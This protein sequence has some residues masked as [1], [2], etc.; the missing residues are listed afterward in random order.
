MNFCHDAVLCVYTNFG[1]LLKR[2][3]SHK[4]HW[5]GFGTLDSG[6]STVTLIEPRCLLYFLFFYQQMFTLFT[7]MG[8]S[9]LNNGRKQ[10]Q[11]DGYRPP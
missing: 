11:I 9:E 7:Y 10:D 3:L 6:Y 4:S 1:V 2:F 5:V 8:Q